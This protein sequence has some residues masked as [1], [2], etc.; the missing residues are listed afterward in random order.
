MTVKEQEDKVRVRVL[1][2]YEPRTDGYPTPREFVSCQ[3]RVWLDRPLEGRTVI[4]EDSDE[5]LPVYTP[6][7]L[8][9]SA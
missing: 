4:D 7:T 6:R 8:D 1:V 2:C 5:E 9:G 3:V